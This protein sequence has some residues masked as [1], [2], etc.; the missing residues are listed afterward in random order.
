MRRIR[1]A[2]V[3]AVLIA[4]ASLVGTGSASADQLPFTDDMAQGYIGFC[5]AG[6]HQVRSGQI[7]VAPFA[8]LA[9]SSVQ[10]PPGYEAP[11]GLAVLNVYLPRAGVEPGNWTGKQMTAA[12]SFT[13]SAHPMVQGTGHDPALIDFTS[14]FVPK[15]DGLIQ[16]RMYFTAPDRPE[17]SRPYPATVVRVTGSTWTQ[18]TGGDVDCHAGSASSSESQLPHSILSQ[19]TA[20]ATVGATPKSGAK[21]PSGGASTAAT[22]SSGTAAVGDGTSSPLANSHA[23][24]S[25]ATAA[26]VWSLVA[27]GVIAA[28]VAAF[29]VRRLRAN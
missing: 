11:K 28:G 2:A 10:V 24:S 6:G 23:K 4:S 27:V 5:D 16:F 9:V 7:G 13:N 21:A 3:L 14:V 15:V 8:A 17:H 12:S 26:I 22:S 18:V 25:S 1:A 19:P 29:A 20:R